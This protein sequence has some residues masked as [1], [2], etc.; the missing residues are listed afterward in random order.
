MVIF[1]P[2]GKGEKNDK[3]INQSDSWLVAVQGLRIFQGDARMEGTT[4]DILHQA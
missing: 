3:K 2:F 4:G 1:V